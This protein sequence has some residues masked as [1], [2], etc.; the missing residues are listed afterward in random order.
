MSAHVDRVDGVVLA[1][2][3]V[4][5][6]KPSTAELAKAITPLLDASAE[7]KQVA[8]EA[9]GR[10][11]ARGL[12]ERD[13]RLM[14]S[15]DG[16]K[17]ALASL[18]F[19]DLPKRTKIDWAWAKKLLVLRA[20][21]VPL[22]PTTIKNGAKAAWLAKSV[23][24]AFHRLTLEVGAKPGEVLAALAWRAVGGDDGG[25]F[26]LKKLYSPSLLR[27]S[28]LGTVAEAP[29]PANSDHAVSLLATPSAAAELPGFA[30]SVRRAAE[31][32]PTGQWHGNKV[33]ISHVWEELRRRGEAGAMTFAE[34][35][36]RL[37]EANRAALL[38]LSRADMVQDMPAADVELSET[39]HLN[40]RFHFVQLYAR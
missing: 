34:F 17:Q 30:A 1:W 29:R 38:V 26:S 14:L 15:P 36:R 35:Q 23:V 10:L 21:G 20:L 11:K 18:G 33:F 8:N 6:K 32:T 40:A 22:T 5:R 31:A 9:L 3:L 25:P 24:I 12:I 7:P 28:S 37:V 4:P 27:D 19:E 16:K 2:L 13:T 39:R